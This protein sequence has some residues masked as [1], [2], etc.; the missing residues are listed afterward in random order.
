MTLHK[1]LV[2]SRNLNNRRVDCID[3]DDYW[4]WEMLTQL[5]C[6]ERFLA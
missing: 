4:E 6:I 5:I 3:D 1:D 2:K